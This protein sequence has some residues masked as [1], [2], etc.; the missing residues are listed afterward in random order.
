MSLLNGLLEKE[1]TKRLGHK[2]GIDEI[3]AHEWFSSVDSD[4]YLKK[5]I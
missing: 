3:L 1:A 2:G 5:S 4:V